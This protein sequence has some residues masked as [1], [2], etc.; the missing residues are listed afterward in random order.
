MDAVH[1]RHNS[2]VDQECAAFAGE[3]EHA[4]DRRPDRNPA[5]LRIKNLESRGVG[6]EEREEV[7]V[8]VGVLNELPARRRRSR[9]V[10]LQPRFIE[11]ANRLDPSSHAGR[12]GE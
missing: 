3:D 1:H 6:Q 12:F 9:P 8:L 2:S 11:G 7:S 10:E 4:V 5:L